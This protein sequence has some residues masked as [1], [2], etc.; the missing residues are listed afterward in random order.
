MTKPKWKTKSYTITGWIGIAL[1][2]IVGGVDLFLA[3]YDP[4]P[5]LSQ[6]VSHRATDQPVF[7]YITIA[8]TVWLMFHWFKILRF[9]EKK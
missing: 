3:L 1:I 2:L 6:Y 7:G 9:W 8:F 5:T 4:L